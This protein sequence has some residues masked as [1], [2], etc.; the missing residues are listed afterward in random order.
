MQDGAGVQHLQKNER[1]L[2]NK[3]NVHLLKGQNE[4]IQR[5]ID[6]SGKSVISKNDAN[7]TMSMASSIN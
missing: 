7:E 4:V 1:K 3:S 5:M 6:R 2:L